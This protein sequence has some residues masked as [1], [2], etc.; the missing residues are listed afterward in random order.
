[1]YL[2]QD[3]GSLYFVCKTDKTNKILQRNNGARLLSHC[4]R[5]MAIS[6]T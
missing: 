1:M 2:M 6:T 5:G 3:V 4:C